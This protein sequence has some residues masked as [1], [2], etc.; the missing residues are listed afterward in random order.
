VRRERPHN[1][2]TGHALLAHPSGPN[3]A[4][5]FVDHSARMSRDAQITQRARGEPVVEQELDTRPAYV[6]GQRDPLDWRQDL[7]LGIGSPTV[8][9]AHLLRPISQKGGSSDGK[10]KQK[11]DH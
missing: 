6:K 7:D 2:E 5:A 4:R 1:L 9:M 10:V 8:A 11:R 3:D